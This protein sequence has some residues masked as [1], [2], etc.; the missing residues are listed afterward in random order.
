M[1]QQLSLKLLLAIGIF[2]NVFSKKKDMAIKINP[3][4]PN[5]KKEL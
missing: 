5:I 2:S 1:V 4:N 3:I